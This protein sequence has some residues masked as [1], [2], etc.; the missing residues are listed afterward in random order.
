MANIATCT[1]LSWQGDVLYAGLYRMGSVLRPNNAKDPHDLIAELSNAMVGR[2]ERADSESD[3]RAGVER[4]V[5]ESLE[6]QP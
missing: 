6:W 3:A 4:M 2:C 1:K 5:I